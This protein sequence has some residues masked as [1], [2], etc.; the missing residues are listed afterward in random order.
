MSTTFQADLYLSI[1]NPNSYLVARQYQQMERDYEL[2]IRVKPVYPLAIRNPDYFEETSPLWV[3]YLIMDCRR[4]AEYHG[5]T[6]EL[7]Q[8]DPIVQDLDSLEISKDQP[9][10]YRL[11]RLAA[12]SVNRG[13][14][15]AFTCE[16]L[17]LIWSGSVV[18]W[19]E[20]EHLAH[21]AAR[22]GLDLAELDAAVAANA[23]ELDAEIFRN[24]DDLQSAGHWYTPSF[25]FEGNLF[26]G[27]S[28][29]ELALS[30][31]KKTGLKRRA[32]A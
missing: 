24:Q 17:D 9:Y 20:G 14:G 29:V 10:I 8:P 27:D 30:Q 15:L 6:F 1:R 23:Q 11:T 16:L 12:E 5:M 19:D 2:E 25:V 31:M 21:C 3:P 22:A 4:Y 28:R 26:F 13:R 7:P 18:G 32:A